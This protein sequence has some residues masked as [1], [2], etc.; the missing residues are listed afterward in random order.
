MAASGLPTLP[1][2][3]T[4]TLLCLTLPHP[5]R[6]IV[7]AAAY[8]DA[9]ASALE[10]LLGSQQSLAKA[11]GMA[12]LVV[13]RDAAIPSPLILPAASDEKASCS[14]RYSVPPC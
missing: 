4:R 9:A 7:P 2:H 11:Q 6:A 14:L 1:L 12:A 3:V 10:Q 13:L 5:G 8:C